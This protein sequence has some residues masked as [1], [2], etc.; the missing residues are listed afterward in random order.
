MRAPRIVFAVCLIAA[1]LLLI[2][3]FLTPPM[4]VIDGSVI[5]AVGELFGFAALGLAPTLIH[6]RSIQFNHGKTTLTIDDDG[7]DN[8]ETENGRLP[9]NA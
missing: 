4:G 2:A 9:R 1:V 8:R 6:G 7:T 3:G 5:S